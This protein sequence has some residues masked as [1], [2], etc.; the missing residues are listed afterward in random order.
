M[1]QK[2]NNTKIGRKFVKFPQKS[3]ECKFQENSYSIQ[4]KEIKQKN[5]CKRKYRFVF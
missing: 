4:I 3:K 1:K 5:K 2:Q